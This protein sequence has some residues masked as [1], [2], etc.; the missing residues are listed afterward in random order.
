[1]PD[2]DEAGPS[3][4]IQLAVERTLLA[5]ER[6]LM[7]WVRTA[8]SLIS[9]GFTIYKFFQGLRE[10]GQIKVTTH[11]LGSRNFGLLM[12][13]IGLVALI[14]ASIQHWQDTKTLRMQYQ[15]KSRSVA[16]WVAG[17]I[18]LLGSVGLLAVLLNQ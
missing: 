15:V 11:L 3:T 8:A 4:S 13:I 1:M 2:H 10:T 17:L 16:I 7:A 9:F 6:T 14:M 18:A 5:H 12:I